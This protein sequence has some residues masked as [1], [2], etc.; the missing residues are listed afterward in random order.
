MP[1]LGEALVAARARKGW[2]LRD[3]ERATGVHNAHLSQI[4][5]G[6]IQRPSPTV[7]FSLAEAYAIDFEELMRMGGLSAPDE[8]A[9]L[10]VAFRAVQDLSPDERREAVRFMRDLSAR[11]EPRPDPLRE[12]NDFAK[13]QIRERTD[14]VLSSAGVID[15]FPTPL[16]AVAAAAGIRETVDVGQLPPSLVA[17]KP[18]WLGRVIGA[19]LFR[20]EVAFV[21]RTQSVGRL[22]FTQGHETTHKI[23]PWH[24]RAFCLD[25]ERIF[26]DVEDYLDLEANVGATYLL[27]QGERFHRMALQ[28]QTSIETPILLAEQFATSYHATIRYYVEYHPDELGL[29]IAGQYPRRGGRIPIWT[30][31]QSSRFRER[32]GNMASILPSILP[33]TDGPIPASRLVTAARAAPGKVSEETVICDLDGNQRT[34][35]AECW[36]NQHSNFILISPKVRVRLGRRVRLRPSG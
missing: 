19:Y 23:L 34:F 18:S 21:D 27:F 32:F 2:S 26:R 29:V 14:H 8:A 16:D 20:E 7:L 33:E 10:G 6:V 1:N 17:R 28:Y 13:R 36:F 9:T 25:D 31:T 3:A 12:V 4:E 5:K 11:Q 22:R 15:T 30:S 24:Q 35:V